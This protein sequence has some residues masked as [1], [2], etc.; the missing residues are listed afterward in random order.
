MKKHWKKK[1][2]GELGQKLCPCERAVKEE[3]F[4]YLEKPPHHHEEWL[5][6]KGSLWVS[7]EST[8]ACLWQ[9]QQMDNC[10]DG[11]AALHSPAWHACLPVLEGDGCW[12]LGFSDWTWG[13]DWGWLC[14]DRL[15]EWESYETVAGGLLRGTLDHL[16]GQSPSFGG[17]GMNEV[18]IIAFPFMPT[19]GRT[20]PSLAP[21]LDVKSGHRPPVSPSETPGVVTSYTHSHCMLRGV[22]E[23]PPLRTPGVGTSHCICLTP[24]KGI[25]T[26]THGGKRRQATVLKT[27]LASNILN[28]K[29]LHRNSPTH[30]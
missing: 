1:K 26:S 25:M 22:P 18:Q 14:W 17:H 21:E 9:P 23:L 13:K 24:I 2:G 20:L 3:R 28:P 11:A 5:G 30:K 15:R 29:K 10:T 6:Q 7:E 16:I 8:A 27:A 4:L 12:N 19:E